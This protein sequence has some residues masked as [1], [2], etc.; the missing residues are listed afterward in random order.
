MADSLIRTDLD[1]AL[2]V[3]GHLAAKVAFDRDSSVDEVANPHHFVV[4]QITNLRVSSIPSAVPSPVPGPADSKDVGKADDDPLLPRE[5][6]ACDPRHLSHPCRCLCRGL[7]QMTHTRPCRRMIRHF[8]HIFLTDGRTFI[9][10]TP[11]VDRHPT[12]PTRGGRTATTSPI[13]C[14]HTKGPSR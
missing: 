9:S 3:L 1:L 10:L 6:Y 11:E 2:D 13:T 7:W 5:V 12:T 8:S 14:M 4:G